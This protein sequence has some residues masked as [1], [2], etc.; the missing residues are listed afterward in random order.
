MGTSSSLF[1]QLLLQIN[2]SG[3]EGAALEIASSVLTTFSESENDIADYTPNPFYGVNPTENPTAKTHNLTL[4]D[5]GE[6]LQNIPLQPLIQPVRKVDVIFAF[7][8]SAD[9]ANAD[10]T[11]TN[12]PNGTAI[13]ASYQRAFDGPISNGTLFPYVPG[14]NTMVNLGLNKRA[15]FFGCDGSNITAGHP[16]SPVPPLLV[17]VPNAP[18]VSNSN[19]TTMTLS[20]ENDLRDSLIYNGYNI[21]TQ[22]NSTKSGSDEKWPTC[23]ACAIIHREQE[24]KGVAQS[25]QCKRCFTQH[26][27][28]GSLAPQA[29]KE[30]YNPTLMTPTAS[31]KSGAGKLAGSGGAVVIAAAIVAAMAVL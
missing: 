20:Y 17:Y 14:Q 4:V 12:W 25:D 7:D 8:N 10:G 23:V 11:L 6:D 3:I 22:G 27:W 24:R 30:D 5:G 29:P 21:A 13:V 26:C 19:T 18:W 28:D 15:T 31:S 16:N 2:S 9:T 1:N